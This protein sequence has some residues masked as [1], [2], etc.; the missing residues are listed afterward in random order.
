MGVFFSVL[1]GSL[2]GIVDLENVVHAVV[3]VQA[4]RSQGSPKGRTN[5]QSPVMSEGRM[6]LWPS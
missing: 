6:Y 1:T 2:Q 3:S 4:N 5:C